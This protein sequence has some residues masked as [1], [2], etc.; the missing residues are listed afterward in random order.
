MLRRSI[1]LFVL[2]LA[3]LACATPTATLSPSPSPTAPPP[4]GATTIELHRVA[5]DLGCD[6]IGIDY[7]SFTFHIDPGAADQVIALTNKAATLKTYWSDGFQPGTDAERV[8]RDATGAVVATDGQVVTV[9]AAAYPRLAGHFVCLGTDAIYV[10][11]ADP[12]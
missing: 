5:G 11:G 10:F 1:A 8:I 2:S 4:S 12:S 7:T 9:P 6:T 3:A